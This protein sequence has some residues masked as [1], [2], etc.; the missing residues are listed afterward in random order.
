MDRKYYILNQWSVSY[1]GDPDYIA[2]EARL[3][4][5]RG[6]RDDGREVKTSHIVAV[7]GRRVTTRSG[8]VYT[9]G[10]IDP[11]YLRWL[12]TN[13]ISYNELEPITIRKRVTA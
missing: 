6:R 12:K 1:E 2:P 7:E 3:I 8:N 10:I 13:G 11:D 5:L 9:L 4:H